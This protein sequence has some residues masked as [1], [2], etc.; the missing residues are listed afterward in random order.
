MEK[1]FWGYLVCLIKEERRERRKKKKRVE[2]ESSSRFVREKY[3]FTQ[4]VRRGGGGEVEGG[5]I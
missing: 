1:K 3:G 2:E 4:W 5:A